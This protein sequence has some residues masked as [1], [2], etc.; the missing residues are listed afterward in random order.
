MQCVCSVLQLVPRSEVFAELAGVKGIGGGEIQLTCT[1]Q[2][3]A[4]PQTELLASGRFSKSADR[5]EAR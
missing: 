2:R 1:H 5:S 3:G 4:G